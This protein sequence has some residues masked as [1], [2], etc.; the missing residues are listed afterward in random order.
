M[1]NICLAHQFRTHRPEDVVQWLYNEQEIYFIRMAIEFIV[2]FATL[3]LSRL[4][5]HIVVPTEAEII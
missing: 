4:I 1:F 2:Y 3:F 5:N